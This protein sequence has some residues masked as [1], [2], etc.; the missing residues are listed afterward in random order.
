M[1]ILEAKIDWLMQ[2]GNLPKLIITVDK[3]PKFEGDIYTRQ[4]NGMVYAIQEG[5]V[6]FISM[7]SPTESGAIGGFGGR[8]ITRTLTDGTVLK[9]RDCWSGSSSVIDFECKEVTVYETGSDY[10]EIGTAIAVTYELAKALIDEM[11]DT[12][13]IPY[14]M[15][16][17]GPNESHWWAVSRSPSEYT[18][19][20]IGGK[21]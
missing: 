4:P 20:L 13:L 21:P 7:G 3:L 5:V 17:G 12:Y 6:D 9:S 19:K 16:E 15:G 8:E 2:Y 18:K 14:V 1:K 11:A 10:P